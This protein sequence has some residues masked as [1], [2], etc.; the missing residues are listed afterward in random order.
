MRVPEA[1]SL[2]IDKNADTSGTANADPTANTYATNTNTMTNIINTNTNTKT[3]LKLLQDF[4]GEADQGA[5]PSRT[6]STFSEN[7]KTSRWVV[8]SISAMD[9]EGGEQGQVLCRK[10][11][12]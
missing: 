5:R 6:E 3:K 4:Q 1:G 11:K 8:G 7:C 12:E 9:S 10:R 2:E